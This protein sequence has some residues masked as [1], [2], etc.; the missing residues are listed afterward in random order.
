MRTDY[1]NR[2]KDAQMIICGALTMRKGLPLELCAHYWRDV[3]GLIGARIPGIYQYWQHHLAPAKGGFWPTVERIDYNCPE[4]D[5]FE[6]LSELTFLSEEDRQGLGTSSAAAILSN[7]EQ[8]LFER[9]V[10]YRTNHGNSRTYVDGIEDGVPNGKQ[11]IVK[12]I[13][14]FKKRDD[15]SVDDFRKYMANSFASSFTKSALVL[16][17]RL[18]LLEEYDDSLWQPPKVAHDKPLEKQYQAWFE[19]AFKDRLEMNQFFASEEYSATVEDQSKY[20][21]GIHTF[22][23]R[24]I[25][26]LVYNGKLTLAGQRSYAVAETITKIGAISQLQDEVANFIYR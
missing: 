10:I 1:A 18:H 19:I 25:Y 2:D 6:G 14:F 15:V 22:P 23:E 7:D 20:I 21:R 3:H 12:L 9:T 16:K 11:D 5:Q 24:E 4:E 8:N 26:T 17:L 13:V